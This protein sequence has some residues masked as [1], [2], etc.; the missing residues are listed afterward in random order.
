MLRVSTERQSVGGRRSASVS[1]PATH[2]DHEPARAPSNPSN[3]SRDDCPAEGPSNPSNPSRDDCP[4]QNSP[5]QAVYAA[6]RRPTLAKAPLCSLW[7]SVSSVT[8]RKCR[9][10]DDCCHRDISGTLRT[11]P[12][13]RGCVRAPAP[14]DA[15]GDGAL[16]GVAKADRPCVASQPGT[17]GG[18]DFEALRTGIGEWDTQGCGRVQKVS[19]WRLCR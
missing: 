16:T 14:D 13:F 9:N 10:H 3:P 6:V 1:H 19:R 8:V 4:A 18:R 15:V 7:S 17:R 2:H 11:T 5:K 12:S